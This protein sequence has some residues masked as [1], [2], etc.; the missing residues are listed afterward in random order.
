[1]KRVVGVDAVPQSV[2]NASYNAQLNGA[3]FLFAFRCLLGESFKK[4]KS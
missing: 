4:V 3:C 1:M 2:E